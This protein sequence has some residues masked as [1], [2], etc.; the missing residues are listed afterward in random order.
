MQ[1]DANL[2]KIEFHEPGFY[3]RPDVSLVA[4]AEIFLVL[5]VARLKLT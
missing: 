3:A 4:S 2:C 1:A 5:C